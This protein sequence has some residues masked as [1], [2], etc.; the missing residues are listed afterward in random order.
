MNFEDASEIWKRNL[1]RME[2]HSLPEM[3]L[4]YWLR[5]GW[6]SGRPKDDGG[7]K[8]Y[9]DLCEQVLMI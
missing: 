6:E 1:E 2:W 8:T 3:A 4:I 7:S 5:G 9:C